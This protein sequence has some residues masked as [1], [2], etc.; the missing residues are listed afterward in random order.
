MSRIL[1]YLPE[2]LAS[3]WRNRVRTALSALGMIIGI[4]S[5]IAVLGLSQAG[6]NGIK[7]VISSGGD[8]GFIA[9]PDPAQ[10]DPSQ[11][12]INYRDPALVT[13]Y[14]GDSITRAI[15]FYNGR[16]FQITV[17]GKRDFVDVTSTYEMKEGDGVQM[18][19]GRRLSSDDVANAAAV[20]ILSKQAAE[21]LFGSADAALGRSFNVGPQHITCVGVFVV[22]GSLFNSTVGDSL[23]VPYTTMHRIASGTVDMIQFWATPGTRAVDAIAAV[24]AAL[25]RI[26]PRG[27]Y[28]VQDQSASLGIFENVLGGIGI[29]LTAIGSLALLVAGVGIMNIMLVSVT[30]RTREIG[31]RKAIGARRGD[32]LV[33][34]LIEAMVLS[35]LGGAL[36]IAVG[37]LLAREAPNIPAIA[38]SGFPT[39][40]VSIPSVLLAFG[41]SVAIGLF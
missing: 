19:S 33:Q 5:V 24:R 17:S 29:G 21:K 18:V 31:I 1:A 36:G 27:E 8:P 30:E 20:G 39:P 26:H 41:V 6:Q 28:L 25:A 32:I 4:A 10:N 34:F 23:Y 40:V 35:G 22:T 11:A 16:G 9:L 14:A 15:P 38:S 37:A 13:A 12:T 3:L 7:S 2:A